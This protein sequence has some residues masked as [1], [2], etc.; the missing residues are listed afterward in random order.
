MALEKNAY[1]RQVFIRTPKTNNSLEVNW[2]DQECQNQ[3]KQ[4]TMFFDIFKKL[5]QN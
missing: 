5:K 2:F 1:I 4:K 3:F